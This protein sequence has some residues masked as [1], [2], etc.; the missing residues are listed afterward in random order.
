MCV[1]HP[2]LF[3]YGTLR[4]GFDGPMA[5]RLQGATQY[6]GRAF[7][8]GRLYRVGDYPA[9]LPGPEGQV[10]GDLLALSDPAATLA[11]LDAYEECA[12]TYPQPHEYRREK[13]SVWGPDGPIVAWAYVYAL[14]VT[15]LPLIAGGDFLPRQR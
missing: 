13:L 8:Q 2:P 14:P 12:V 3:V 15:D 1:I 9:F 10:I 6:I 11:W 5:L 4:R 7:A